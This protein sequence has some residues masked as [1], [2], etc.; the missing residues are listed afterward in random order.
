MRFYKGWKRHKH[1]G[2]RTWYSNGDMR[3]YRESDCYL[4]T[5][6]GGKV[7]GRYDTLDEAIADA[8]EQCEV[9]S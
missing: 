7:V 1:G 8:G 6:C 4:L 2:R 3:I 9:A 5:M